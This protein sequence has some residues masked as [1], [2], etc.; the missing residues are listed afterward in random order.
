MVE[1][2]GNLL[3]EFEEIFF[4]STIIIKQWKIKTTKTK[5]DSTFIGSE[6]EG[7]KTKEDSTFIGSEG[8]EKSLSWLQVAPK[9]S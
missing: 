3:K 4:T 9:L 1:G 7:K 6:G 2:R 8:E 5:K